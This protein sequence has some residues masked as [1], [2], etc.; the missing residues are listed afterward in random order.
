[1]GMH[2]PYKS[3][4]RTAIF[5]TV[6]SSLATNVWEDSQRH[7]ETLAT[8]EWPLHSKSAHV[9]LRSILPSIAFALAAQEHYL[10]QEDAYSIIRKVALRN[11]KLKTILLSSLKHLPG[12]FQLFRLVAPRVLQ[13]DYSSAGFRINWVE[14]GRHR[15]AFDVTRCLYVDLFKKSNSLVP[16][17]YYRERCG[18]LRLQV[19]LKD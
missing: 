15:L 19:L 16:R 9:H 17:W 12:A 6:K 4:W 2:F 7:F 10:S 13:E 8:N 18:S 1:M 5:A 14:N 11:A 3:R